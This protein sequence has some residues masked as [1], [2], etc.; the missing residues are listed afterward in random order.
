VKRLSREQVEGRKEKAV[1]FTDDVLGDPDRADEI[2]DESVEDYAARKGIEIANPTARKRRSI[3]A[4]TTKSK[5]ELEQEIEDL[6]QEN[7]ELRDQLDAVA[8]IVS[9]GED[10]DEDEDADEED[11]DDD[12]D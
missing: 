5:A 9:P 2:A 12:L 6:Q 11:E 8:D 3:M 7:E 4:R 1:R 10:E